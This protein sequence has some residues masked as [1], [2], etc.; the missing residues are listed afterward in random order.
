MTFRLDYKAGGQTRTLA[1]WHEVYEGQYSTIDFD[2]SAL[3]GQTVKFIL[4]VTANGSAR[5]D[6]ALWVAPR[7]VRYGVP[8]ATPTPTATFTPTL[9][10]TPTFTPTP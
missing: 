5:D 4:V 2:L 1:S 8:P 10:P 3:N 6:E 7:I 9:T